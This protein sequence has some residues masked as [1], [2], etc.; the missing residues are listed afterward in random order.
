[1]LITL[2]ICSRQSGNLQI[3]FSYVDTAVAKDVDDDRNAM[4]REARQ[5]ASVRQ[6]GSGH[7]DITTLVATDKAVGASV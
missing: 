4:P 5:D 7:T 1:V 3:V 6:C 2:S